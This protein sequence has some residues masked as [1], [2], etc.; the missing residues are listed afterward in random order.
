VQFVGQV[1][2]H[3]R[4]EARAFTSGRDLQSMPLTDEG[5]L[6]PNFIA[7]DDLLRSIAM[8]VRTH[9]L[10][11]AGRTTK[12]H[13]SLAR[14]TPSDTEYIQRLQGQR[15]AESGEDQLTN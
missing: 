5:D 14:S 15:R 11:F 8:D 10:P 3:L 7:H 6:A 1:M 12:A 13:G 9:C 4:G 2:R